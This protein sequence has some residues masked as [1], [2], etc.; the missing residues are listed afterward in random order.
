MVFFCTCNNV[1]FL[2]SW[3]N[4]LSFIGSKSQGFLFKQSRILQIN[5]KKKQSLIFTHIFPFPGSLFLSKDLSFIWYHFPSALKTTFNIS[6]SA[7]LTVITLF[8]FLLSGTIFILPSYLKNTFTGSRLLGFFFFFLFFQ[9]FKLAIHVYVM[10][11]FSLCLL[12]RFSFT[13]CFLA[14]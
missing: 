4:C 2:L 5:W 3:E 12:S 8:S 7:A 14:A 10:C 9:H 6:C 11:C 13:L 1:H